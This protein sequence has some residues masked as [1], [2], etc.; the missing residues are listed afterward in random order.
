MLPAG[1][2]HAEGRGV[3][4][5]VAQPGATGSAAQRGA[6]TSTGIAAA[7]MSGAEAEGGPAASVGSQPAVAASGGDPRGQR[8][9]R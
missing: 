8:L 9:S 6:I 5:S 7:S 4:Q 2:R 1:A 3:S